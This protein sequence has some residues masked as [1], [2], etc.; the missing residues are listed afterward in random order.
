MA[1]GVEGKG[2]KQE[3]PR[4]GLGE[5]VSMTP[6]LY[7]VPLGATWL[8][9]HV[10]EGI[11]FS[12]I[13]SHNVNPDNAVPKIL[14]ICKNY[15][16]ITVDVLQT[17]FGDISVLHESKN[18]RVIKVDEHVIKLF[19]FDPAASAWERECRSGLSAMR[20]AI[21][22]ELG[23]ADISTSKFISV[24][25]PH[26]HACF[27]PAQTTRAP[28]WVMT[29]EPGEAEQQFF[30][31]ELLRLLEKQLH[32]VM[33]SMGGERF[34]QTMRLENEPYNWLVRRYKGM[35]TGIIRTG[36]SISPDPLS[37]AIWKREKTYFDS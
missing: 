35:V 7:D 37:H 11:V 21:M 17:A 34:T 3:T 31:P 15:S 2:Q 13:D 22:L 28:V 30:Q 19:K 14:E 18:S 10:D 26:L 32:Y 8:A 29:Y 23:L 24:R 25:V 20:A 1:I 33:E 16:C 4:R 5:L 6:N 27:Y 9:E 36:I 12:N